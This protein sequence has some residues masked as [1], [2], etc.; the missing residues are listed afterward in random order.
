MKDK[1]LYDRLGISPDLSCRD[2][3]KTGKKLL[4]RW[5]P[6]K[7]PDQME[8]ASR[9]FIE[10]K[11]IL[12]IL[13]DAEKREAYHEL[14]IEILNNKTTT[15]LFP[16]PYPSPFDCQQGFRYHFPQ[17]ANGFPYY[18]ENN[19]KVLF[20]LYFESSALKG[21]QEF[22]INYQRTSPC[23]A[24]KCRRCDGTGLSSKTGNLICFFCGGLGSF[25]IMYCKMCQGQRR[26]FKNQETVS[27]SF[28]KNILLKLL[29]QNG[30]ITLKNDDHDL[31]IIP[32][33]KIKTI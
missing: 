33:L 19:E 6:D 28:E 27:I 7:N 25:K 16:F 1:I 10:I 14:G 30:T 15:F 21:K 13:G 18:S 24:C 4:L 12:D 31:I 32:H 2:I 5:H 20:E 3:K 8:E 23:P 22:N 11:E 9:K 17:F 26:V 29:K